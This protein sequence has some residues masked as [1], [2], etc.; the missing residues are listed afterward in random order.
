MFICAN[1]FLAGD[2]IRNLF[3]I[4]KSVPE[5]VLVLGFDNSPESRIYRPGLSTVHVHTQVMAITAMQLLLS[6]ADMSPRWTSALS[7][8]K[9]N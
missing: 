4:G 7:T 2:L 8:P 3:T 1:D 9:R 6:P 5:D